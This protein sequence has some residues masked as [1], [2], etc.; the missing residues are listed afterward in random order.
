MW[1]ACLKPQ[2]KGGTTLIIPWTWGSRSAWKCWETE[3]ER[4]PEGKETTDLTLT[5]YLDCPASCGL[6]GGGCEVWP[7]LATTL[8]PPP[9]P[10]P[11]P[12]ASVET[13]GRVRWGQDVLD[14]G[15]A[16][17]EISHQG[18]TTR[19]LFSHLQGCRLEE[20]TAAITIIIA[21]T[22]SMPHTSL[23]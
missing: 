3:H 2:H 10:P 23:C 11:N 15:A 22:Y 5:G 16:H 12:G 18:L 14:K 19:F 8:L 4:S 20:I 7:P 17:R 13:E 1:V 6:T 21:A 9:L